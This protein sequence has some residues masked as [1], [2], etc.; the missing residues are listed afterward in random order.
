MSETGIGD[1]RKRV[2]VSEV[3]D[4]RSEIRE[5]LEYTGFNDRVGRDSKVFLKPNLTWKCHLPGVTTSPGFLQ[6]LIE[7]V[8]DYTPHITVGESS[9]GY[10][11]YAAREAFAGHGLYDLSKR[12]GFALVDL[13][14]AECEEVDGVVGGVHLT[15]DLPKFLLHEVDLFA[16]VPVPKVH[17]NTIVSLALKNQWGCL[18][19]VMRLRLH[20]QFAELIVL[21]NRK[22]RTQFAIFDAVHM[23]DVTGPLIG[24]PVKKN[25]VIAANDPGAG[26]LVCCRIMGIDPWSIRHHRTAQREGLFP[27][28]GE[29]IALSQPLDK[30][31]T[32][33]FRLKRNLVNWVSYAAFHSSLVT[34]VVY[35]SRC[36]DLCH[37]ALYSLRKNRLAGKILYGKIGPPAIEGH[38]R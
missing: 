24:E 21:V 34:R 28:K 26:S 35:D 14:E 36:A 8:M 5:A 19:D 13:G 31:C 4:L 18:P 7:A 32:H 29:E 6:A 12:Y 15:V 38:R 23:L 22:L 1:A 33:Q 9:G 27:T 20:P 30:W 25:L 11:G 37:Q 2:F 10:N 3:T 17:S 16:T